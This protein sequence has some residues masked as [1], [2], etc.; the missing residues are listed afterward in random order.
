MS[1]N[2]APL[3]AQVP[4]IGIARLTTAE[5]SIDAAPANVVTVLTAATDHTIVSRVLVKAA[6]TT[7]AGMV[8]LWLYDGSTYRL[9]EEI[10]VSAVTPS[11]TV[12]AWEGESVR[13]TPDRPMVLPSGWSLRATTEK[14]EKFNVS[15]FG[16]EGWMRRIAKIV[17]G[18]DRSRQG[19]AAP[20][21]CQS[22]VASGARSL[23]QR[24]WTSFGNSR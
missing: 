24:S 14:G 8:R 3:F 23:D 13:I 18:A 16:G 2:T 15:A 21:E 7:T 22:A 19:A 10:S 6:Q 9:Y 12:Q 5:T 20:F 4:R 17:V 1:A 11:A